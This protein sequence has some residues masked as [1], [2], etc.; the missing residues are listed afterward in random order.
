MFPEA[1][2]DI[3]NQTNDSIKYKFSTRKLED[4]G[5]IPMAIQNPSS[6]QVIIQLTDTRDKTERQMIINKSGNYSFQYLKPK[7]YKIRIIYDDNNN[8][9]WD[10][11][12]FLKKIQPEK[13]EYYPEI[14]E[15]RPNWSLN[16]ALTINP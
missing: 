16:V 7:E 4:Y 8:G 14:Q 3:F 11:G 15:V 9:K 5:D 10:T 2:T 6:R 1:F 12:D 13:V